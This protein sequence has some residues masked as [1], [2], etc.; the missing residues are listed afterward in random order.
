MLKI[1]PKFLAGAK[2]E[3]SFVL[4]SEK[5]EYGQKW[6]GWQERFQVCGCLCECVCVWCVVCVCG[7]CVYV[8]VCMYVRVPECVRV[9]VCGVVCMRD[10]TAVDRG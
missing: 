2:S 9:F 6:N 3:Y 7:V 4:F 10:C 8:Y 5:Q 1:T